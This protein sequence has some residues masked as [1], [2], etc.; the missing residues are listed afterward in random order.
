MFQHQQKINT[1]AQIDREAWP[2]TVRILVP[3]LGPGRN[4]PSDWLRQ[5][6][7]LTEFARTSPRSPAGDAVAYHFRSVAAATAFREAFPRL[8]LADGTTSVTCRSPH[9]PNG[10]NR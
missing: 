6:I 1:Q 5:H 9:L 4:D 8:N 2:V 10:P 7:G 3:A